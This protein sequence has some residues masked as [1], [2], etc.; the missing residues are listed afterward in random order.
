MYR[1]TFRIEGE[2][3]PAAATAGA[4][5]RVDVWCND[6]SDLLYVRGGD[7][8][9]FLDHVRTVAGISDRLAGDGDLV[10]ITDDCLAEHGPAV[11]PVL[12]EHG[13]LLLEP[14]VYAG[15]ARRIRVLA[16]SPGAL[17]DAYR[18]LGEA[19]AVTVESKRELGTVADPRTLDP[20]PGGGAPA[21]D[22]SPRQREVLWIAHREGYFE[23]PRETTTEAIADEVGVDRRTAE[24]HLRK[25]ERKVIDALADREFA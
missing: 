6:H 7:R 9:T 18:D 13:C 19:F 22:L 10:A 12:A 20:T 21:A 15:G 16:L 25:A 14:I 23:I 24:E 8:A 4:D 17:S 3:D 1:A 5:L 11:D 2:D